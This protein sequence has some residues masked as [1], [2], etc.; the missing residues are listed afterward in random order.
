M[1]VICLSY[2]EQVFMQIVINYFELQQPNVSC[3][4]LFVQAVIS[5]FMILTA[6]M[7]ISH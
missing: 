7:H 6:L 5:A 2:S 1:H 3:S 4:R